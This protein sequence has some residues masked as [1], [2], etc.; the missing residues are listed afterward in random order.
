MS[1]AIPI[2]AMLSI[3]PWKAASQMVDGAVR[4]GLQ[5]FAGPVLL[6]VAITEALAHAL[7]V[8]VGERASLHEPCTSFM[9]T[10]AIM[11]TYDDA[12]YIGLDRVL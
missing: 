8:A 1:R 3:A 11:P 9:Y 7:A 4:K 12:V 5:L 6:V 2:G 10:G